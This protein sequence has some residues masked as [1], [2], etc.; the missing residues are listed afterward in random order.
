M[1]E[2]IKITD[3]MLVSYLNSKLKKKDFEIGTLK[4]YIAELEYNNSQKSMDDKIFKKNVQIKSL[5]QK[6]EKLQEELYKLNFK[7]HESLRNK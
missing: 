1:E 4:A 7:Y 3:A 6:I 2:P 5:E